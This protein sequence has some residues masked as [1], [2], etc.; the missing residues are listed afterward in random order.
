MDTVKGVLI[1]LTLLFGAGAFLFYIQLAAANNQLANAK[2]TSL[3][4]I[5]LLQAQNIP[6]CG[7]SPTD[8]VK[9]ANCIKPVLL[10]KDFKEDSF[11]Q[12][13]SKKPSS[14]YVVI[15]NINR[16]AYDAERFSFYKNRILVQEG[17]T[18]PGAIDYNVVCRFNFDTYCADGDVLEVK[19][20]TNISGTPTETKVFNKN[21]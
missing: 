18:I 1:I 14:G 19:Y 6:E 10:Q 5:K 12:P 17:C 7:S 15:K 16:K 2:E 20:T 11:A 9:I 3:L 8:Y 13:D 21:C 4:T